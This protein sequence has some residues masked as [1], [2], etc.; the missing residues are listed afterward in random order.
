[1][2]GLLSHV[3]LCAVLG[4][5]AAAHAG[6]AEQ[7]CALDK[8]AVD[9]L[10][11]ELKKPRQC[12]PGDLIV[13]ESVGPRSVTLER[14]LWI[15]GFGKHRLP[16]VIDDQIVWLKADG[17]KSILQVTRFSSGETVT[18]GRGGFVPGQLVR[19]GRY[20]AIG[21]S[22]DPLP[23]DIRNAIPHRM[24]VVELGK[25]GPPALLPAAAQPSWP[26]ADL[27]LEHLFELTDTPG[28]FW[29][30]LPGL[31][32]S[33]PPFRIG[34]WRD[35]ATELAVFD[36]ADYR[37]YAYLAIEPGC[38]LVAFNACDA[39]R[40]RAEGCQ[41][42]FRSVAGDHAATIPLPEDGYVS[43]LGALKPGELSYS[44]VSQK[45]YAEEQRTFKFRQ[46]CQP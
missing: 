8:V 45:T 5:S 27:A 35:G 13:R 21:E 10:S 42:L 23:A 16:A 22:R 20:F 2:R 9:T 25:K 15:A 39:V 26:A 40:N 31:S 38:G 24:V 41:I 36:R 46:R 19:S 33:H 28:T 44:W 30:L 6:A 29:F 43:H 3:A 37:S 17:V 4:G 7:S 14:A 18:L 12:P 11:F 34:R 1:M 32:P